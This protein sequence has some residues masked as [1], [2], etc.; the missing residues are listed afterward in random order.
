V[1][2][3]S[4]R[5]IFRMLLAAIGGVVWLRR[6]ELTCVRDP[7]AHSWLQDMQAQKACRRENV[8]AR[9]CGN[10]GAQRELIR[11]LGEAPLALDLPVF[12]ETARQPIRESALA[13]GLLSYVA[14]SQLAPGTAHAGMMPALLA[15]N[16]LAYPASASWDRDD[17][18]LLALLFAAAGALIIFFDE[19]LSRRRRSASDAG[20]RFERERRI[21]ASHSPRRLWLRSLRSSHRRSAMMMARTPRR[22]RRRGRG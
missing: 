17:W 14:G 19:M 2:H 9:A 22:D 20:G 6:S 13:A 11:G 16:P 18:L 8:P 3:L 15:D 5:V 1:L 7:Q 21:P 4:I 10:A 12:P